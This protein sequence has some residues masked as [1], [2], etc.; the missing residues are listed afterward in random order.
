MR[1]LR[2]VFA[3]PAHRRATVV[4]GMAL[5]LVAVTLLSIGA[6]SPYTH[7][8][9]A[10][11]YDDRYDRTEQI[12]IGEVADLERGGPGARGATVADRGAALYVT[13]GCAGC[14]S[15]EG[16]GGTVAKAIAGVDPALLLRKVRG[17][18]SGMPVFSPSAL[19]DE[20]V[21]EIAAY[22]GSLGAAR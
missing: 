11:R 14:H 3:G 13:A 4:I 12:V 6:N 7:A 20:E 2:A 22:L 18:T 15:L 8:N 19:T 16:R 9:L 1:L 21:A 5:V 17:G 10:P